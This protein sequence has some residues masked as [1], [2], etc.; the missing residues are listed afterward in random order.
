LLRAFAAAFASA[1]STT[2]RGLMFGTKRA[3]LEPVI[4]FIPLFALG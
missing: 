3:L 1:P 4:N 2:C